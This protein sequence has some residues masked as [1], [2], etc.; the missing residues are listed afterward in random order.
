MQT[1]HDHQNHAAAVLNVLRKIMQA[2]PGEALAETQAVR[3]T[4]ACFRHPG[5][6]Q[7]LGIVQEFPP[8]SY[9]SYIMTIQPC[10]NRRWE[11]LPV[12]FPGGTHGRWCSNVP[13]ILAID[14]GK[15]TGW[16]RYP[17]YPDAR[18]LPLVGEWCSAPDLTGQLCTIAAELLKFPAPYYLRV[19]VVEDFR[20]HPW[21]AAALSWSD[22]PAPQV[23]GYVK[24][25]CATQNVSPLVMQQPSAK[26][27]VPNALL[28]RLGWYA[29]TRG[30][31]H[32]RDALRHLVYYIMKRSPT[33]FVKLLDQVGGETA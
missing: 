27:A 22:M 19:V 18:V 2:L 30:K 5:S 20:L 21:K 25:L 7:L 24:V 26:A 9:R 8:N 16:A 23:I 6:L 33:E 28:K 31:P 1:K 13:A 14:P 15:T 12:E 11:V 29:C 17:L 32:A 4:E 3:G 10:I